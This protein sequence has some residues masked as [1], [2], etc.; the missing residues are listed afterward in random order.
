[1]P[2]TSPAALHLVDYAIIISYLAV[3]L[4]IGFIVE[5]QA[6]KSAEAFFLGGRKLP[7]WALGASGMASNVDI[8]G[9][10]LAVGLVYAMG[11]RGFF[12]EIRGGIVL[13]MALILAFMG[14][15]NRRSGVMTNAE[16]MVFRFGEGGGGKTARALS[17]LAEVVG[18][19]PIIA[20]L[21]IGLEIFVGPLLPKDLVIPGIPPVHNARMVSAAIIFLVVIYTTSSGL[22]GVVWTDVFQGGIIM[23]GICYMCWL[24]F[25]AS[26]LPDKFAVSVPV[27]AVDNVASF[28]LREVDRVDWMQAVPPIRQDV[29]GLYSDYNLFGMVIFFFIAQTVVRGCSGAGGGYMTQRYLAAKSEREAGL[30]SLLWTILLSFRWPMVAAF[31][32][33]GIQLGLSRG[34]PIANPEEV[35]PTVIQEI[36][37][38]GIKGILIACFLAAFMSTF[39]SFVNSTASYW[40]KDLYQAF[41][42]PD[43]SEKQQVR[44][45]RLASMAIVGLGLLLSYKLSS[46]NNI[47]GWLTGGLGAGLAVPL[48]LRWYWWRFNGSG[49]AVGTFFGMVGAFAIPAVA[50]GLG[51]PLPEWRLFIASSLFAL[52]GC[53]IGAML[54]TPASDAVLLNFYRKTRPFGAWG[55]IRKQLPPEEVRGIHRE[56]ALEITSA[57]LAIPWQLSMFLCPMLIVLRQWTQAMLIGGVWMALSVGL[58]FV[59]YRNLS[60]ER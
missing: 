54:D 1:M 5:R 47:W 49:F 27:A 56:S 55:A 4:V 16:W 52:I 51:F 53:I 18:T 26:E 13:I 59:W 28:Q 23:M 48:L 50:A 43:A 14:K 22:I 36:L 38:P 57:V 31:A 44:Q 7:W 24:G 60:Q 42:K 25:N 45:G 2:P 9:T 11:V 46:I 39:S 41:L 15:W 17:A 19:V 29:P 8:S 21:A 40:V 34:A 33:L 12:I 32:V 10:A 6:S 37:P 30:L 58:Y 20:Y 3:T 35:M